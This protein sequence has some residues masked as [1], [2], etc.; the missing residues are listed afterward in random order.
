MLK[1][2]VRN[3][4]DKNEKL[5]ALPCSFEKA[6][7]MFEEQFGSCNARSEEDFECVGL[8]SD[9]YRDDACW[10]SFSTVNNMARS[11]ERFEAE[12]TERELK[13]FFEFYT[14]ADLNMIEDGS[15]SFYNSKEEYLQYVYEIYGLT[16]TKFLWTTVDVFLNDDYVFSQ[17]ELNGNLFQ[18]SNGVIIVGN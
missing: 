15:V 16:D 8:Y 5:V 17:I 11:L 1:T 18:A 10:T 2:M 14:Y 6:K 12:Y 3:L 4:R 9:L 7:A 13:A